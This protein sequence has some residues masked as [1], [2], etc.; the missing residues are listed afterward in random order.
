[1]RQGLLVAVLITVVAVCEMLDMVSKIIHDCFFLKK[2][3]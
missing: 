1:M 3:V 2:H